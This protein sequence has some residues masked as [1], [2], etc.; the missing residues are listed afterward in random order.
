MAIHVSTGKRTTAAVM[1]A[2]EFYLKNIVEPIKNYLT[3]HRHAWYQWLA[4]LAIDVAKEAQPA[5]TESTFILKNFGK[6]IYEQLEAEFAALARSA[7]ST[8]TANLEKQGQVRPGQANTVA[9]VALAD[10]FGF[11]LASFATSAAFEMLLPEKLN[12][13]N[14]VGPLLATLAGFEEVTKNAIGPL[15]RAGV[16]AP[17][18]YAANEKFRSIQP[19]AG[20]AFG[21]HA[22]RKLSDADRAQLVAWAGINPDYLPALEAGE[23]RPV[24]AR[25]LATLIQDAPFDVVAM[26]EILEDNSLSPDHVQTMLDLLQYNSTKNVRN[27]YI[28]EAQAAYK[29]GVV[30]D[31]E[32]DQILQSVGWSTDAIDLVKKK[33]A[34]QKRVQIASETEKLVTLEITQGQM[35]ADVGLQVLEG[36]GV[37][38]WYGQM[39]VDLAGERANIT[40]AKKQAAATLKA[41]LAQQRNLTKA[42]VAEFQRGVLDQAGLT[43]ALVAIGLDPALIT[44]IVA[45]Q[46]ATRAGRLKLVFGQLLS[47][48][49][50]KIL[51]DRVNAIEGQYKKQLI[52]LA[53]AQAQLAAL[54]VDQN[55][56][57]ALI[58]RW[59]AALTATGKYAYLVNPLTGAKV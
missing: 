24:S 21:L 44:S 5:V 47:P 7:L 41:E 48:E 4:A 15:L 52:T 59:A 12:T 33:G 26:R 1:A 57:N 46:D 39:I 28:S 2:H 54:N 35:A 45:V 55:E 16:G 25:A 6:P 8:V 42:A 27:S 34:L 20:Q 53:D 43:A 9:G 10:A 40:A 31:T 50:A 30:G 3:N 11:G 58:A 51:T 22:R 49:D 23:Y 29:V 19:T 32:L 18:A 36:A 17:S 14:G 37:Q 56:A 13:L 38:D